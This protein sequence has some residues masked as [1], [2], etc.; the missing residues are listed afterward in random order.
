M[1]PWALERDRVVG[2]TMAFV[3]SS[4]AVMPVRHQTPTPP[5]AAKIFAL[6]QFAEQPVT[7]ERAEILRRVAAFKA[8]Q[9]KLRQDREKYCNEMLA[10]TR[11]ALRDGSIQ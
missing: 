11:A 1:K 7:S 2:Q 10:R 4:P 6:P 3:E 5:V 9:T 8:H